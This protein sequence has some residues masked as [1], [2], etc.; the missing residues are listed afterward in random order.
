MLP[1][2]N[3]LHKIAKVLPLSLFLALNRS[4][5]YYVAAIAHETM[6]INCFHVRELIFSSW[7]AWQVDLYKVYWRHWTNFL[8]SLLLHFALVFRQTYCTLKLSISSET[9][10]TLLLDISTVIAYCLQNIQT[11]VIVSLHFLWKKRTRRK[12]VAVR[13]SCP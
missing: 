6:G 9:L 5:L 7:I 13:L 10:N 4:N 3:L 1:L 8:S 2:Y 12:P 11:T